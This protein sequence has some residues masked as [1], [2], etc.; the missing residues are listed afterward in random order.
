MGGAQAQTSE[1]VLS[2]GKISECLH[3]VAKHSAPI[4][5]S[6]SDRAF[7]LK[8]SYTHTYA[9]IANPT[10]SVET[11]T[12]MS[13]LTVHIPTG[14][15]LVGLAAV[16]TTYLLLAQT[17]LVSSARKRAKIPYPQ[18]Y[19]DTAEAAADPVK[20]KYN[21]TQRAHQNTLETVPTFFLCLF[22]AGIRHPR[23]AAGAG[24]AWIVGRLFYTL[25]YSSGVV[26]RR[27]TGFG[28]SFLALLT[29]QVTAT[30][31]VVKLVL[32]TL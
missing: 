5:V 28:I 19:A 21:C 18:I 14:Y 31:S 1:L 16:G 29:L 13:A 4:Y 6:R 30:I 22:L 20:H 8:S 25:G 2:A 17:I 11:S 32:A 3:P 7:F 26:K 15:P 9:C 27:T 23:L 24:F 10:R 12:D